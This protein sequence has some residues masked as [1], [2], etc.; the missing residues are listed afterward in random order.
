MF[1]LLLRLK[2]EVDID[3]NS[4]NTSDNRYKAIIKI[5]R[6]QLKLLHPDNSGGDGEKFNRVHTLYEELLLKQKSDKK[7]ENLKHAID[8]VLANKNSL[9]TYHYSEDVDNDLAELNKYFTRTQKFRRFNISELTL[10]FNKLRYCQ[11]VTKDRN[12]FD[13]IIVFYKVTSEEPQPDGSKIKF[14]FDTSNV[15]P[16]NSYGTYQVELGLEMPKDTVIKIKTTGFEEEISH[17]I[18]H[19]G[20]W[21]FKFDENLVTFTIKL[22]AKLIE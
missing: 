8:Y 1:K 11:G 20:N 16:Y 5:L 21:L 15:L 7:E 12:D 2:K 14:E 3:Y 19:T 6:Q 9:L 10:H 18:T 13:D 4:I 22:Y 17:K